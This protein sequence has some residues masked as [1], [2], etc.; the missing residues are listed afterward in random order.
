MG[1]PRC[2][3][4]PTPDRTPT[5]GRRVL[6]LKLA[7]TTYPTVE[8]RRRQAQEGHHAVVTPQGPWGRQPPTPLTTLGQQA[9]TQPKRCGARSPPLGRRRRKPRLTAHPQRQGPHYKALRL[10]GGGGQPEPPDA[11]DRHSELAAAFRPPHWL[12]PLETALMVPRAVGPKPPPRRLRRREAQTGYP[13]RCIAPL[14]LGRS[15]SF[16][17]IPNHGA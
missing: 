12:A 15:A 7:E 2:S 9:K 8:W 4:I 16:Y 10:E 11:A 6:R 13:D 17:M 5:E 1:R 3:D 14:C